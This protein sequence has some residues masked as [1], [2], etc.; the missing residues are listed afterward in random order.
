VKSVSGFLTPRET[1][2]IRHDDECILFYFITI[3]HFVV[4]IS[5]DQIL[6]LT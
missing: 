4:R 5:D 1:V 3:T 2:E 6:D